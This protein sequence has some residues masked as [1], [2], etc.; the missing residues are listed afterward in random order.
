MSGRGPGTREVVKAAGLEAADVRQRGVHV[1]HGDRSVHEAG[2]LSREG[3]VRPE[4]AAGADAV[5]QG[6]E[7]VHGARGADPGGGVEMLARPAPRPHEQEPVVIRHL[8]PRLVVIEKPAGINT[9]RHP[10]ERFTGMPEGL[11]T[12]P[13]L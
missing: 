2:G 1:L 7:L 11:S 3:V 13:I 10:G 12:G 8:D 6:T 4:V 9:V 5:L